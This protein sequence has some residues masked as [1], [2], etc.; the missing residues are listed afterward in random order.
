VKNEKKEREMKKIICLLIFAGLFVPCG[1]AQ[2]YYNAEKLINKNSGKVIGAWNN[3]NYAG[4]SAKQQSYI[5]NEGQQWTFIKLGTA[6]Y[7]QIQRKGS[8]LVLGMRNKSMTENTVVELQTNGWFGTQ[9]WKIV[10][11]TNGYVKIVNKN[12]QNKV[13]SV[14]NNSTNDGVDIVLKSFTAAGGQQWTVSLE[15]LKVSGAAMKTDNPTWNDHEIVLRGAAIRGA[16]WIDATNA[17]GYA[18]AIEQH[19]ML[20]S[21]VVRIPCPPAAF[22]SDIGAFLDNSVTPIVKEANL[23]GMYAIVDYHVTTTANTTAMTSASAFW[24]EAVPRY[25]NWPGVLFQVFNE[26]T[27]TDWAELKGAIQPLINT[28]RTSANNIIIAPTPSYNSQLEKC[29]GD[30]YTG[31]NIAYSLHMYPN[32]FSNRWGCVEPLADN[33]E[34]PI[35]MTEWGFSGTLSD[36]R[37][38]TTN[39]YAAPL[40]AYVDADERKFSWCCW[41]GDTVWDLAMFEED[42]NGEWNL[43]GG[44]NYEGEFAAGWL[45]DLFTTDSTR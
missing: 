42:E 45:T 44:E 34:V 12:D 24:D 17:P 30:L 35:F 25:A 37:T 3:G 27:G 19:E 23:R 20:D 7:Y 2:Y 18:Y 15:K 41:T 10:P 1:F 5:Q 33:E 16:G 38:G 28:I 14:Y 8:S 4:C 13:L 36:F 11:M 26:H 31:S 21:S 9:Q 39:S 43:T 29:V 6:G 32:V 40:R 22:G